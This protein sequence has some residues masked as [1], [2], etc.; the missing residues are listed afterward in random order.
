[1]FR[2]ITITSFCTS[3]M[4]LM[5]ACSSPAFTQ[6][7][8]VDKGGAVQVGG[9]VAVKILAENEKL[10]VYE[11]IIRPGDTVPMASRLGQVHYTVT[12]GTFER[13]YEDGSKE[14][15]TRKTGEAILITEKRPYAVK[16][17]GKTTIDLIEVKLK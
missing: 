4:A 2:K 15:V 11:A 17:I 1:M 7:M 12:G 13:T 16:N 8:A 10:Q 5:L 6:G 3:A 9:K 14:I